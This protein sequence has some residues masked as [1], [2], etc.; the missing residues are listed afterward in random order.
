MLAATSQLKLKAKQKS[1]DL[2]HYDT[3][4]LL[5][6]KIQEESTLKCCNRF[7]ELD[8]LDEEFPELA[9]G[10]NT[11]RTDRKWVKIRQAY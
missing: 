6:P 4:K 9:D 7:A 3:K 10:V 11:G 1:E 5:N 8:T 2:T